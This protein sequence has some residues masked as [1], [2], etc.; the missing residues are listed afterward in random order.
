MIWAIILAAGESKRMGKQK[1]LLPFGEKTIV[2]TVIDNV[3]RSRVEKALVVLG[4]N[5][6]EI[7]NKIRDLPVKIVFNPNFSTGMLSSVKKGFQ[8]APETVQAVL[9]MLGDQPTISAF[10]I[11]KVIDTYEKTKK[12]IIL[13]IYENE[14]GHPILI[15]MKYRKEVENLNPEIGLRELVYRQSED[16]LEVEVEASGIINDIDDM[17]DYEREIKK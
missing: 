17:K 9:I 13:P 16:I 7:E 3:N 10:T 8:E 14:R 2:E 15:D 1:L 11:N 6:D 5:R 12:G 4:A